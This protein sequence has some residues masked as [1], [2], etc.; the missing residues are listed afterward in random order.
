MQ[1]S[2][3]PPR[4]PQHTAVFVSVWETREQAAQEAHVSGVIRMFT[5]ISKKNDRASGILH[6]VPNVFSC[7]NRQLLIV[8][9]RFS[10]IDQHKVKNNCEVER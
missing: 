1:Q 5:N 8:V 2:S 10:A 4:Q 9:S 6:R 7:Y 3:D